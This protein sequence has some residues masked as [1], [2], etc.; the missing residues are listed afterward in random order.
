MS[1][2]GRAIAAWVALAVLGLVVAVG[3]SYTASRLVAQDVG[4]RGE[5]TLGT[6][7]LV[8]PS[9][10]TTVAPATTPRDDTARDDAARGDAG[11][12]RGSGDDAS[13]SGSGRRSPTTTTG[14]D[15]HGDDSSDDAG[16]AHDD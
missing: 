7:G 11:A 16:E 4:L 8:P 5:P 2:R 15:D 9:D 13:G 6:E 3:V 10:V 12:S 1:R 14:S